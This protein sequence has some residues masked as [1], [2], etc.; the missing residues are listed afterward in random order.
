MRRIPFQRAS[1]GFSLVELALAL[2]IASFVL[3]ALLGLITV[4][5]QAGGDAKAETLLSGMARY[6]CGELKERDF[7]TLAPA[8]FH[9]DARGNPL[10]GE[11][12]A[13]YRC[14]ASFQAV[15]LPHVQSNLTTAQLAFEWP[16]AVTS[17]Q[18][19]VFQTTIA[20]HE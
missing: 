7:D 18:R 3:I 13:A 4:G 9:F 12:G 5:Y 10:P 19:M 1:G 6:V 17:P 2:G 14:A 11:E 15:G 16:P 8:T 20:R